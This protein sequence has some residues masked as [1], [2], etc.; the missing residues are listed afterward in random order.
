MSQRY[1]RHN[2]IDWFS[3]QQLAQT[4]AIV[5]GAGAVGNEVIKNLALL[6]VGEIIIYDLD[7]IEEHNLTRSA[8]FREAHVGQYKSEVA[9]LQARELDPNVK[10]TGYVGDFWD[11]LNFELLATA[12]I[13]FCCVDNFEARLRCNTLCR[14]AGVDFVNIG[15]DSRFS[16]VELYPLSQPDVAC[17]ECNLPTSVYR[18]ISERYSCGYLRKLSYIEKRIPTTI[19]TSSIAGSFAVSTG[20]RLG[21]PA[22]SNGARRLYIDTIGGSTTQAELPQVTACPACSIYPAMATIKQCTRKVSSLRPFTGKNIEIFT[23]EPILVSYSDKE[24]TTLI[25]DKA[26]KFDSSFPSEIADDP[27]NIQIV[28][29]DQFT[30][31]TLSKDFASFEIPCKFVIARSENRSVVFEFIEEEKCLT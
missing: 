31:E 29:S 28:I 1:A 14:L 12:N 18:R 27:A 2:L 11:L 4:K 9:A 8:L 16:V 19:I 21:A 10:T 23:S 22:N 17:Y 3:Q 7:K 25:F 6:G 20:L 5:I 24:K 15:I 26:S 30:L 13:L